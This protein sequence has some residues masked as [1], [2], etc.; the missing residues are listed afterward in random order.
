MSLSE[1]GGVCSNVLTSDV[2]HSL[3]ALLELYADMRGELGGDK[4]FWSEGWLGYVADAVSITRCQQGAD[5]MVHRCLP[6][7]FGPKESLQ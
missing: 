6:Y 4:V 1:C 2:C 5:Y 3:S 7:C